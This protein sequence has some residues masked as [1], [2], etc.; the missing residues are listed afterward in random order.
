MPFLKSQETKV[1][2][3]LINTVE[4][5]LSNY[6]RKIRFSVPLG[7]SLLNYQVMFINQT[8]QKLEFDDFIEVV[9]LAPLVSID[10]II[11][12]KKGQVLLGMRQNE[13]A[14]DFWFVPG[15][16]IL[17]DERIPNAFERIFKD[18]L[19]LDVNYNQAGFI[20]VFEHIY[21]TNSAL[22]EGFGTHYVVLSHRIKLECDLEIISD[23]QHSEFVWFDRQQIL[24]N[25]KVHANTKA[26]FEG[27]K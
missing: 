1:S 2:P 21:S 3:Y 8:P 13:P 9:R 27:K 18:E 23:N 11:E 12:N 10:L 25:E 5:Y 17:K 7:L 24:N 4:A 26:Y 20:G 19:G 22:K 14:K 6:K 15:G 16:R